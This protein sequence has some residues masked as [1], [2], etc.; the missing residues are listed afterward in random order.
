MDD[1]LD[2]PMLG[3]KCTYRDWLS[4]VEAAEDWKYLVVK[5]GGMARKSDLDRWLMARYGISMSDAHDIA[6][7][8]EYLNRKLWWHLAGKIIWAQSDRIEPSYEQ[9]G[10]SAETLGAL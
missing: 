10:L 8:V 3:G 6:N 2:M 9:Y 1:T 4:W 7:Y 5:A